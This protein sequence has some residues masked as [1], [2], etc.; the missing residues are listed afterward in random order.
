MMRFVKV[1]MVLLMVGLF[2]P[3]FAL[4][5]ARFANF[6]NT[7]VNADEYLYSLMEPGMPKNSP[8]FQSA[9][10]EQKKARNNLANEINAYD[11]LEDLN[12]ALAVTKTFSAQSSSNKNIGSLAENLIIQRIK[13]VSAHQS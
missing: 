3:A 10:A 6:L 8:E 7:A 9:L 12:Q 5:E 2:V 11:N 13:F 1:C 4:D